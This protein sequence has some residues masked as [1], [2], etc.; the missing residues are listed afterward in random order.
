MAEAKGWRARAG[1]AAR[2]IEEMARRE[3]AAETGAGSLADTPARWGMPLPDW[4]T[5]GY[6]ARHSDGAA[7]DE[8]A[9]RADRRRRGEL[10]DGW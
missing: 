10:G 8:R 2:R 4:S 6:I 7:A 9:Q 5:S 3:Q 1:E